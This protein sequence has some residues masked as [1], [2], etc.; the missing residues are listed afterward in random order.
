MQLMRWD[1]LRYLLAVDRA[2]SL[3][4]A[5]R[6][7]RVDQTTVGRRLDALQVALGARLVERDETGCTLTAAGRRAA[8]S[9][10]RMDEVALAIDRDVGGLDEQVDGV[11]RVATAAGFV[12]VLTTAL[13]E[14]RE[15][16]PRLQLEINTATASVN[17]VRREADLAIRMTR[18]KQPSLIAIPK[19]ATVER[20]SENLAIFDFALT[21][22]E[23]A[24][25]DALKQPGSRLVNEPQ[26]VPAWDD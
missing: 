26:W 12:P 21:D 18:D 19:T 9:A 11:V 8:S 24:R 13:R 25:I 7:L 14:L 22:A 10:A 6:L 17:M 16:H 23:M 3:L 2:G 15:R 5:A 4:G 20:L 1:D